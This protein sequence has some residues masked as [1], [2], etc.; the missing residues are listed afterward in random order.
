[1]IELRLKRTG[2][3]ACCTFGEFR[4][5]KLKFGCRTL[6]LKDGSDL[7]CKQSCRLPEGSYLVD[8]K[9]NNMGFFV[10]VIRYRVKGFAV[11]PKFDLM[12]HHFTNL[13]N[14]DIAIGSEYDGQYNIKSN[15]EI[16]QAFSDACKMLYMDNPHEVYI[17]KVYKVAK[18]YQMYEHDFFKEFVNQD[19][20]FL[21]EDEDESEDDT[22]Q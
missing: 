16:R 12:N 2:E 14:G 15:N 21:G 22:S 17:L 20:D 19:W 1:M 10:P 5:P 11:K 3:N 7:R 9:I 18:N 4:I 6:E 8:L 13:L